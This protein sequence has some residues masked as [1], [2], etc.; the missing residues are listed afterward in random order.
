MESA[1]LSTHRQWCTCQRSRPRRRRNSRS[2]KSYSSTTRWVYARW[3]QR[4]R[5]TR[6]ATSF[7]RG[8]PASGWS[9]KHKS[10]LRRP[11]IRTSQL[12]KARSLWVIK[13]IKL[14]FKIK[15][16]DPIVNRPCRIPIYINPIR[17]QAS[18]TVGTV[19]LLRWTDVLWVHG[20]KWDGPEKKPVGEH[21]KS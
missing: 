3:R 17:L 15:D 2:S 14:T 4:G 8:L 5:W 19:W 21:R 12:S 16:F 13:K 18:V 1:L 7:H 6:L 11:K 20:Q 9:G 10:S